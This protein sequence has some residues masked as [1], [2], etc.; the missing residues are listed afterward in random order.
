[1]GLEGFRALGFCGFWGFM[2][3][4]C[5]SSRGFRVLAFRA[6]G[7]KLQGLGLEVEGV[8]FGTEGWG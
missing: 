7:F 6:F 4:G 8:R 2:V 1:M 3:S 5:W